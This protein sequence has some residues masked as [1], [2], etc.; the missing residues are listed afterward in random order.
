V[1][2]SVRYCFNSSMVLAELVVLYMLHAVVHSEM[3][4]FQ[5]PLTFALKVLRVI[6]NPNREFC[7]PMVMISHHFYTATSGLCRML[8]WDSFIGCID[9]VTVN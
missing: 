6:M 5:C 2:I 8:H 3:P 1:C 4:C 9:S 7:P